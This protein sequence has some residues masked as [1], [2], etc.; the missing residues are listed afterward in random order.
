MVSWAAHQRIVSNRLSQLGH[1]LA[2]YQ[3]GGGKRATA[4]RIR[5]SLSDCFSDVPGLRID[6]PRAG[7]LSA[8]ERLVFCLRYIEL[9]Q[10]A[11][12]PAELRRGSRVIGTDSAAFQ[13]SL[14]H[15]SEPT[16]LGMIS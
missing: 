9:L 13:L 11:V 15:I 2:G 7:F 3:G 16:R 14:I 6:S 5:S 4:D 10:R 8:R 12:L 1:H